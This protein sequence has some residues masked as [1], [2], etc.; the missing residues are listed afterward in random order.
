MEDWD[1][2]KLEKVVNQKH[3]AEAST[4][5]TTE[6]VSLA[7]ALFLEEVALTCFASVIYIHFVTLVSLDLQIFHR[8]HREEAVR[9]VLDL[10]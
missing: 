6:I 10:P 7:S 5:T 3:A 4:K 1:Q 8:G 9:M 2:E